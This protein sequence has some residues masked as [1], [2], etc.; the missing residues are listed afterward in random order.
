MDALSI[1]E[2]FLGGG[3]YSNTES[4]S[5]LWKRS[6]GLQSRAA[7][8]CEFERESQHNPARGK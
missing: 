8:A 1:Q 4:G 2:N 3:M 6:A 7:E 5:N